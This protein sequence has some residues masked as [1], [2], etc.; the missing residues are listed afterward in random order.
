MFDELGED[1]PQGASA[2]KIIRARLREY[3]AVPPA[4]VLNGYGK[5]NS[6][7]WVQYFLDDDHRP[8]DA[9][10]V[11]RCQFASRVNHDSHDEN[12]NEVSGDDRFDAVIH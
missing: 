6:R 2:R 5:P 7:E 4:P 3:D 12:T 10:T 8:A 11:T 1:T 9:D